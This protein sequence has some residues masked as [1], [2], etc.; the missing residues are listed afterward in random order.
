MSKKSVIKMT[1]MAA[2]FA[3]TAVPMAASAEV[4]GS[5]SAASFYLWRGQ[6]VSAGTAQIAGDLN[7]STE[8]GFYAGTWISSA[9]T[10]VAVDTTSGEGGTS[11]ET[12]FYAGFGGEAGGI[13]YDISYWTYTYPEA[14]QGFG[15]LAEVI[16]GLGM[17][18]FSL[19]YYAYAGW[20]ENSSDVDADP[21]KAHDL[22]FGDDNYL[23]LGYGMGDFS[24]LVGTWMYEADDSDYTHV[25]VS[26][27][28]VENLTF[29]VSKV[30][31][32]DD[33]AS[34]TDDQDPL[35]H[36]GYSFPL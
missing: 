13:S 1:A 21:D 2:A 19:T 4:A 20:E 17:G 29:T 11:T 30:V 28:P 36:V 6:D 18:D 35:F 26:Y 27:S 22:A 15:E 10:G 23:T 12:D 33:A 14:D 7:F 3:A 8:S 25:D 9:G 16:L 34:P 32:S 24:F 31:S 5:L